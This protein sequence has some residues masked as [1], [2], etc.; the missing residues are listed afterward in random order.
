MHSTVED[1]VIDA[2][3][4]SVKLGV[5]AQGQLVDILRMSYEALPKS[6]PDFV[7]ASGAVLS[8]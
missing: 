8:G 1:I 7:D 5:Y 3:N 4:T 2:G 6:L